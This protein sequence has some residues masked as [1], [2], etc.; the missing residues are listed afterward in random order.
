MKAGQFIF[1]LVL[2]L[3]YFGCRNPFA[4]VVGDPSA[5]LWTDQQTVGELLSN[6]RN[7]YNLQDSLRYVDCLADN[8]VFLYYDI[9]NARDDQ[10]GRY[11]DLKATGGLFRNFDEVLLTW[12]A[13]P[14]YVAEFS[15]PDSSLEFDISFNLSLYGYGGASSYDLYG[16]AR[17]TVRKESGDR[18]QIVTWKDNTYF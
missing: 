4:P 12:Y 16:F 3:L 17:F 6:F 8:F 18:F 5:S 7:S 2:T 10:W 13:I 15:K 11:T 1:T 9:E 14:S